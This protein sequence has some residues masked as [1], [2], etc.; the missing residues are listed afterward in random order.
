[1]ASHDD[2]RRESDEL[3]RTIDAAL[4]KYASAEAR[5]GLEE[6]IMANL[7]T[8]DAQSAQHTWQHWGFTVALAA[9][10]IVAVAVVWRW[11]QA[12]VPPVAIHPPLLKNA[13]PDLAN[14]DKNSAPPRRSMPHRRTRRSPERAIVVPGPKLDVFPS[15]LPLSEQEKILA[16][17]IAQ[18]PGHAAVVAEAR[19]DDLRHEMEERRQVVAD[20]RDNTR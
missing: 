6:R 1:M 10:L 7:R 9:L 8:A 15:P 20:E 2:T 16:S 19:M 4:A 12:T 11:N 17:Y 13:P 3:D 18:D 5:D 14:R